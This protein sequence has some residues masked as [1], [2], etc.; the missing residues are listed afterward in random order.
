VNIKGSLDVRKL[1]GTVEQSLARLF[2]TEGGVFFV[3]AGTAA[4]VLGLS[5]LRRPLEAVICMESTH[6]N[7]DEC[8]GAGADSA[9][10]V[11]DGGDAGRS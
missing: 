1:A 6:L 9:S 11:A 2:G 10:R 5:L 4:N 8:R 3:S 7:G